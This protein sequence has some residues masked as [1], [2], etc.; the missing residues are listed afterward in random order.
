MN[1]AM[2]TQKQMTLAITAQQHPEH[3]FT[4]LRLVLVEN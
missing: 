3:K 1:Q 4:N 2:M